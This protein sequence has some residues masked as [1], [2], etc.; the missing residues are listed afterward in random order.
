[1]ESFLTTFVN[2]GGA[3]TGGS[4]WRIGDGVKSLFPWSAILIGKQ[5]GKVFLEKLDW[6]I[7]GWLFYPHGLLLMVN[8]GNIDLLWRNMRRF[9]QFPVFVASERVFLLQGSSR[10]RGGGEITGLVFKRIGAVM[11]RKDFSKSI[12]SSFSSSSS[13]LRS[14]WT[15]QIQLDR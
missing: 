7:K 1:M 5:L 15:L 8:Q 6:S 3:T 10:S 14:L 13:G 11:G 4:F 12:C 2:W 9:A